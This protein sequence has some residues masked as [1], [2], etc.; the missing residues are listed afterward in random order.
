MGRIR[1]YATIAIFATVGGVAG[2]VPA[3]AGGGGHCAPT[4]GRSGTVVLEDACFTPTT[5][6][7][8][9][10][11]QITFVNRDAFAHNVSGTGWGR[12]ED[13][14]MGDRY[15]ASF[16]DEGMYPFACTLHP[17]M[18]GVVVVGEPAAPAADTAEAQP[19]A[20]TSP[21]DPG[22]RSALVAGAIG[23]LV[24]AAAGAAV[25]GARR[26]APSTTA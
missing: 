4:E 22:D 20:A 16:A 14:A 9:A 8:D 17:G 23:L 5:V 1:R 25:V 3:S 11:E 13:L 18:N 15:T 24:G 7:A 12:Y 26:R 10:G 2:A 6:Y 21:S 19:L